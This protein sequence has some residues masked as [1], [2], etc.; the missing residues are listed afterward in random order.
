MWSSGQIPGQILRERWEE[1]VL[2]TS[3]APNSP[4]RWLCLCFSYISAADNPFQPLYCPQAD[5]GGE[6]PSAI[7]PCA[8]PGPT[9][10]PLRRCG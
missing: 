10:A 1:R 6:G 7:L 8:H 9:T 3:E 2:R 4:Q 5:S